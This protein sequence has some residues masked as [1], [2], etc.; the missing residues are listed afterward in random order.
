MVSNDKKLIAVAGYRHPYHDPHCRP[1]TLR[2][3]TILTSPKGPDK[4]T[5][6]GVLE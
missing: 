3:W 6:I 5:P 2:D 4:Q 1:R